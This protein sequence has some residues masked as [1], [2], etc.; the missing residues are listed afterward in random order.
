[1]SYSSSD[2]FSARL[3]GTSEPGRP[4]EEATMGGN[5]DSH[6][7]GGMD[8]PGTTPSPA[9][10]TSPGR[11]ESQEA[12]YGGSLKCQALSEKSCGLSDPTPSRAGTPRGSTPAR[13]WIQKN[14]C[15]VVS[16][17]P[18]TGHV[19]LCGSFHVP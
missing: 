13:L 1:M 16:A 17:L 4:A 15:P 9:F 18:F 11:Q 7:P 3:G 6:N 12:T 5:G 2:W 8:W 10:F 19:S 14:P